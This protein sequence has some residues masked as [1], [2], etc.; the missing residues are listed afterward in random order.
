MIKKRTVKIPLYLSLIMILSV[1]IGYSNG[2]RFSLDQ[3]I[4]DLDGSLHFAP[5]IIVHEQIYGDTAVVVSQHDDWLVCRLIKHTAG[6]LWHDD[7]LALTPINL[8][9]QWGD[10]SYSQIV[11]QYADSC[12]GL[13]GQ[14]LVLDQLYRTLD[15]NKALFLKQAALE[16][17]NVIEQ[18][19]KTT[20]YDNQIVIDQQ[21]GNA[22]IAIHFY[23]TKYGKPVSIDILALDE[24]VDQTM[25]LQVVKAV[26]YSKIQDWTFSSATLISIME[27]IEVN[28][29]WVVEDG[30]V[31]I[32]SMDS[33]RHI[34]MTLKE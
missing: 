12:S 25:I 8:N 13:G 22:Q 1:L 14:T 3:L 34:V 15:T 2:Y 20:L 4:Q 10:K 32:I 16:G 29:D 26:A 6:F 7:N 18:E 9:D 27:G 31:K 33:K 5:S 30:A 11:A 28:T 17:L 23:T 21:F 24:P 19:R